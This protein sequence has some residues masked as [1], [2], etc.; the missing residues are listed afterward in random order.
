MEG[1]ILFIWTWITRNIDSIKIASHFEFKINE[2][3]CSN[4]PLD[5]I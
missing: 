3:G 1:Q 4:Y 5:Q 2:A